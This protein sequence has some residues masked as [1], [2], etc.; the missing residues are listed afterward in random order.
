MIHPSCSYFHSACSPLLFTGSQRC[1]CFIVSRDWLLVFHDLSFAF[2]F[3]QCLFSITV[4]TLLGDCFLINTTRF[5]TFYLP[6]ICHIVKVCSKRSV[7]P[8]SS[9]PD[10]HLTH[11][12]Y[13]VVTFHLSFILAPPSSCQGTRARVQQQ[14]R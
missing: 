4:I 13:L 1:Q 11:S 2:I 6:A 3:S 14:Q 7:L 8:R 5:F 10:A 12:H 9:P